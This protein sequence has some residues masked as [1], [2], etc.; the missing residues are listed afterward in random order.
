MLNNKLSPITINDSFKNLSNVKI[1]FVLRRDD[2][3][4]TIEWSKEKLELSIESIG[5]RYITYNKKEYENL[6]QEVPI[7]N[8]FNYVGVDC[9]Y[10]ISNYIQQIQESGS[11]GYLEQRYAQI[12]TRFT[13]FKNKDTDDISNLR[14]LGLISK[15]DDFFDKHV[16][17]INIIFSFRNTLNKLLDILG[18][19][20]L[21][22][23]FIFSSEL[24]D[25]LESLQQYYN[26]LKFSKFNKANKFL[27]DYDDDYAIQNISNSREYIAIVFENF[28][29]PLIYVI[30]DKKF[31]T[32]NLR[33]NIN[34]DNRLSTYLFKYT[35]IVGEAM[36]GKTHMLSDIAYK[37]IQ[38]N[39][40]T[41]LIYAQKFEEYDRPIQHIIKQL[42]LEQY[43]FTDEEFLYMLDDWGKSQNE[44]VFLIVDAINET[45]DKNIWRNNF[46]EFVSMVKKYPYISLIMSIRDVEKRVIFTKDIENYVKFNMIEVEHIGFKEIGYPVLKKFCKVFDVNLPKF[47]FT[48]PIFA[49]PGLMFLFFETLQRKNIVEIDE[50]VLKPNFIIEEYIKDRNKHFKEMNHI[51]DRRTYIHQGTNVVA[52]EIVSTEFLEKVKYDDVFNTIAQIH[53]HLL[54]YLISE[55]ILLEQLGSLD[56]VYLYFSYQRFGNYFIAL[57]LLSGQFTKDNLPNE[58]IIY[59]L[60]SSY[61]NHQALIEAL[62]IRLSENNKLDFI[63]IFPELFD[64]GLSSIRYKCFT[65]SLKLPDSL[66]Y[67]LSSFISIDKEEQGEILDLLLG[68]A[69]EKLNQFNIEKNLHPLLLSLSM[70][71]RDYYWSLYIH[72]SFSNEEIVKEIID[73]AW[74]KKEEFEIEG[75]SLYLY[76]LTLGW[77]L[78]SSNRELRDGATKALVNLF[79]DRV[80]IFLKVLKE[81]K[82]V[83]DLYVLERL[84]SVGYGIVLRSGIENGFKELG[85]YVYQT[86]FDKDEV[87]EHIL[88]RDNARFTVEYINTNIGLDIEISKVFPPYK[89]N[90]PSNYPTL[91]DIE[92]HELFEGYS[93]FGLSHIVSSMRTEKIGNYGDFGRYTFQS[94]LMNFKDI[95]YQELSNYACKII[96]EEYIINVK[97]FEE[98]EIDMT[99]ISHQRHVHKVERIG[100]KY[101]W[102]AMFKVLAM[103]ADNYQVKEH[104]SGYRDEKY[105]DYNTASILGIRDIDATSILREKIKTNTL[106]WFSVN[107]DFSNIKLSDD[108]EWLESKDKLPTIK[109]VVSSK[110]KG[111]DYLVLDVYFSKSGDKSK[112]EY[113]SL[114]YSVYAYI[115][116]KEDFSEILDWLKIQNFYGNDISEYNAISS[117]HLREYPNSQTYKEID[118]YYYGQNTWDDGY[119]SS[120][121]VLPHDILLSSTEYLNENSGYD[122]SL[123]DTLHIKLPNKWLINEMGLKQTL[124]DGEWINEEGKVVFFDPSISSCCINENNS[125]GVLMADKKILLDFL[126]QNGYTLFWTLNA[127]KMMKDTD[128][129]NTSKNKFLGFGKISGYGYFEDDV[130]IENIDINLDGGTSSV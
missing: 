38:N 2:F 13:S 32:L 92:G 111:N 39:K 45:A 67:K 112:D 123:S 98:A 78:T 46:I 96:F 53:N 44:L 23:S 65:K 121:G 130:F 101:Q 102:L 59:D 75:E 88:L 85:E 115:T 91:E 70:N 42:H 63:D 82:T 62:I 99:Y 35:L 69:F 5:N 48:S 95:D 122:S 58:D 11:Y 61:E 36:S 81:F 118:K 116:K 66:E 43:Q 7:Q 4:P 47:P 107:D 71:E 50:Q 14:A 22:R 17:F 124:N 37:R 26:L 127:E 24:I 79:T 90:M 27:D 125:S 29:I 80:D 21:D 18:K 40:P 110:R 97:L 31:D 117:V 3:V 49:N 113:R 6:N 72:N 52:S 89:S 93:G 28:I 56:E 9:T 25:I 109:E 20:T 60:F 19:I 87:V 12:S 86:I 126:D 105:N 51:L 30:K 84:Y 15:V 74:D 120:T 34:I 94:A 64:E 1:T 108:K 103:V 54:E 106:W 55:G 68:F 104:S 33:N 114:S 8:Y 100:K 73:W 83:N 10:E 77:F 57:Y 76:G 129:M 41:I 128:Y 119:G 16:E